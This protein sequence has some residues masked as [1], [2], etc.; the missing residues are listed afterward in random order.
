MDNFN[1]DALTN[2]GNITT[3]ISNESFYLW[4]PDY[5]GKATIYYTTIS[6]VSE[7]PY[8]FSH[9]ID[10]V[11]K[12]QWHVLTVTLNGQSVYINQN[13]ETIFT[14]P[15]STGT[16]VPNQ[17]IAINLSSKYYDSNNNTV[18]SNDNNT[19]NG[20]IQLLDYNIFNYSADPS[21]VQ[22]IS[23]FRDRIKSV[24]NSN[25]PNGNL[26]LNYT[27]GEDIL[28]L[29]NLIIFLELIFMIMLLFMVVLHLILLYLLYMI[30]L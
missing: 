20:N 11:I 8:Q 29:E 14:H 25:S 13:G 1:Q 9:Q 5:D 28:I 12:D 21:T 10:K 24:N 22:Q 23:E 6:P 15:F 27:I 19:N 16:R 26:Y 18:K 7:N 4:Y 2:N 17:P 30:L 3:G